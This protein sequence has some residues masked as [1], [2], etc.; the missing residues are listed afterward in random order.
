PDRARLG[1]RL[2]PVDNSDQPVLANYTSISPAP[3]MA[4]IDFGFLE[5]AL[6]AALP[7]AAKQGVKLPQSLN[8]KLAVRVA[9]GY[10][11][12]ADLHQQLG[13]V[14]AGLRAATANAKEKR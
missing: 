10:D 1:I 2:A 3:G 9:M 11:A 4:F 8:G 5:P 7:R 14:L 13:R 12:A 6:L